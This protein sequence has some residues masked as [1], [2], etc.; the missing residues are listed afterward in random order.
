MR[1]SERPDQPKSANAK[2]TMS[3]GDDGGEEGVDPGELNKL[4]GTRWRMC[5][6]D[7]SGYVMFSSSGRSAAID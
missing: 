4:F 2:A 7:G 1:D 5:F 6:I 3:V